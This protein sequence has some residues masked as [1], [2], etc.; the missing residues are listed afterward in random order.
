MLLYSSV[1]LLTKQMVHWRLWLPSTVCRQYCRWRNL[2]LQ[3]RWHDF[4]QIRFLVSTL[5]DGVIAVDLHALGG[6]VQHEISPK[7]VTDL[8]KTTDLVLTDYFKSMEIRIYSFTR[9]KSVIEKAG[10]IK[11]LGSTPA[12]DAT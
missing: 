9:M 1:A 7:L 5:L 4:L 11:K 2:P 6:A 8:S 3:V 12:S 10:D